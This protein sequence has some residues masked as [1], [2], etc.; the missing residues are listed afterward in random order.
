M[1]KTSGS[2]NVG[3]LLKM[4]LSVS[5]ILSLFFIR[6][7]INKTTLRQIVL[8]FCRMKFLY[9]ILLIGLAYFTQAQT[10]KTDTIS[11]KDLMGNYYNCYQ[12]TEG[13]VTAKQKGLHP[14]FVTNRED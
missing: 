5:T 11:Y 3:M 9:T 14:L 2:G 7:K 13:G 4:G 12:V 10:A 1:V 6:T 8:Y